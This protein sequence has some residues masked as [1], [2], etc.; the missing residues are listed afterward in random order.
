MVKKPELTITFDDKRNEVTL[1]GDGV[2]PSNLIEG[3]LMMVRAVCERDPHL[4]ALRSTMDLIAED[5]AMFLGGVSKCC[6]KK[7]TKSTKKVAKK[8]TKKV[9]KR[10]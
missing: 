7:Q 4:M 10:K 8:A 2:T 1:E 6:K 5:R 3:L 9:A